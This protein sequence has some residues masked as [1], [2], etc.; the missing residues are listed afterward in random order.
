MFDVD[1]NVFSVTGSQY[2]EGSLYEKIPDDAVY[3]VAGPNGAVGPVG[4]MGPETQDNVKNQQIYYPL[5]HNPRQSNHEYKYL[6]AV[7]PEP[8]REQNVYKIL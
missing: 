6:K 7:T 3:S 5:T 2:R 4:A 1:V 8:A